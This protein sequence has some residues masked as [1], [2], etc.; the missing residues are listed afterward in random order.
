MTGPQNDP[1]SFPEDYPVYPES[2]PAAHPYPYPYPYP[3]G[4]P[5]G[6][7]PRRTNALAIAS[8][9]C[10]FLF[11]PLAIVFGHVSLSQI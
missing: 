3:P 11:A 1:L 10:G 8:L 4:Y 9:V 5:P 2:P 6:Y 7:P